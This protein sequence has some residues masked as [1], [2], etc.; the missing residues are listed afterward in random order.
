MPYNDLMLIT[1]FCS[2]VFTS[3][4]E[5]RL[6]SIW[7]DCVFP[8]RTKKNGKVLSI[9]MKVAFYELLFELS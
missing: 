2:A 7:Q 4:P 3:F 9:P 1:Y 6:S 8:K 5:V